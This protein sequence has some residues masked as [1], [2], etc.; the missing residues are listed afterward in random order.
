MIWKFECLVLQRPVIAI[1][2]SRI[3]KNLLDLLFSR[4]HLLRAFVNIQ[5]GDGS[6]FDG[7]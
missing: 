7:A 1:S 4:A 5:A 6:Y 2:G 3:F